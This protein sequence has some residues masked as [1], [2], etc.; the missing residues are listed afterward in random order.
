MTTMN[1]PMIIAVTILATLALGA[2]SKGD[3][4]SSAPENNGR[5]VLISI[6]EAEVHDLPIWLET[7]GRVHSQSAPTLAAEVAGRITMVAADTGE[8][9]EQG[10]LLAET[11][12]S[13][14]LL[15]QQA[16]QAGIE[17]LQVHI[18]NGERRVERFETLSAKTCL[19]KSS[20]MMRRSNWQPSVR[21]TKPP[22]HNLLS[23]MTRWPNPVLSHLF[24]GSF[25]NA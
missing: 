17:R 10:Q 22:R 14:L 25:S 1:K 15:Q 8:R 9:I 3:G 20:S 2:C 5:N 24:P 18:A 11:D 13:T 19:P 4:S 6:V 16:A 21:T 7:A 12:T 23:S